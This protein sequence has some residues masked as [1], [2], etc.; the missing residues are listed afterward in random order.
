MERASKK[1]KHVISGL[2]L[3]EDFVTKDEEAT[4]LKHVNASPWNT[5]LSRR[6]QHYGYLYD[7][8]GGPLKETTPLPEWCA[9]LIGRLIEREFLKERPD[10]MIVNEYKQ[11]QGIA[12]HVDHVKQFADGIVSISLGSEMSMTFS[13]DNESV[14]MPLPRCSALVLF[15]EARYKWRHAIDRAQKHDGIRVS[16]TFRKIK[17]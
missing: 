7:Y 5:S 4:L 6:T 11:G 12:P 2:S 9:F 3:V 14:D 13:R 1:V 8:K 16:L 15:G 10:Q 17:K